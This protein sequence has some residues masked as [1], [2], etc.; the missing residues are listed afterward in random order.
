MAW[1]KLAVTGAFITAYV[2]SPA[3]TGGAVFASQNVDA[4]FEGANTKTTSM[5][6]DLYP[7]QMRSTTSAD[8]SSLVSN[9]EAPVIDSS[10]HS[11]H[12]PESDANEEEITRPLIL[13]I[14]GMLLVVCGIW[15]GRR[16]L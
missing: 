5:A 12:A 11:I 16:N 6:Y 10:L 4:L 9:A 3:V 13:S 15:L 14:F 1:G 2:L 7:F 8:S